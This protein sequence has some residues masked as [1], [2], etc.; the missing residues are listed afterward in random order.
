MLTLDVDR[1]NKDRERFA[2]RLP[3][4]TLREGTICDIESFDHALQALHA[5]A[6]GEKSNGKKSNGTKSARQKISVRLVLGSAEVNRKHFEMPIKEEKDFEHVLD[7]NLRMHSPADIDDA[8]VKTIVVTRLG[9]KGKASIEAMF[10]HRPLLEAIKSS[11]AGA[12]FVVR[13]IEPE[14]DML[15][16]SL[17]KHRIRI[18]RGQLYLVA[19]ID[20]HGMAFLSLQGE[21]ARFLKKISWSEIAD[22]KGRV[23]LQAFEQ[24]FADNVRVIMNK[25]GFAIQNPAAAII[26]SAPAFHETIDRAVSRIHPSLGVIRIPVLR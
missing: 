11:L 18:D 12:G 16:R 5:L 21:T 4:G 17:A 7:L 19:R 22:A 26:V 8:Y 13:D 3:P 10:V 14:E 9:E 1:G 15:V 6:T 2:V 25:H 24:A 23:P 20:D